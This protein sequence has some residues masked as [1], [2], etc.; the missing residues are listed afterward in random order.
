MELLSSLLRLLAKS[1][2]DPLSTLGFTLHIQNKTISVYF[3]L[4]RQ[5]LVSNFNISI[6]VIM[7]EDVMNREIVHWNDMK[8][9]CDCL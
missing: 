5:L 8:I 2:H 1:F 9:A 6:A 7:V 4:R 3:M